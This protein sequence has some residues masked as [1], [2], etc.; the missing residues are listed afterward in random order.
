MNRHRAFTLIEI[1][2]VMMIM[3]MVGLLFAVFIRDS[4]ILYQKGQIQS[5]V[6]QETDALTARIANVLRGTF[7]VQTA[8]STSLTVLAYYAPADT[9]PTKVT[10][11]RDGANVTLT[12]IVGVVSGQTYTYP[13]G[14]AKSR[15]I[16]YHF[17]S[18]PSI[19][20]FRYYDESNTLL[21]GSINVTGVHLIEVTSTL[22]SPQNTTKTA[23]ASTKIELRNLKTNL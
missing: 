7:Q 1:M 5:S 3:V 14:N 19:P 16:T 23:V 15:I 6:V 11:Q 10:I 17:V 8:N 18:S 2:V 4:Y 20:L 13:A 22:Y 21:S 9:T 12:T